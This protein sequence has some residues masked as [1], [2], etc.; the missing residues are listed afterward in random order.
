LRAVV[1]QKLERRH[2]ALPV[3]VP[4]WPS[5]LSIHEVRRQ[6]SRA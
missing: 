1:K 2:I 5:W 4:S 3:S 6:Q